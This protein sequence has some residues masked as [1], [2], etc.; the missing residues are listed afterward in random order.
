MKQYRTRQINTGLWSPWYDHAGGTT[1]NLD[2]ETY[3]CIEWQD[4]PE[5]CTAVAP[6]EIEDVGRPR[7]ESPDGKNCTETGSHYYELEIEG[8]WYDECYHTRNITWSAL[9]G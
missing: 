7:C 5:A 2:L 4:K 3:D 1:F 6:F 8:V 9:D